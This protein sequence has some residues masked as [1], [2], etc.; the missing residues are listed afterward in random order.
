M[1]LPALQVKVTLEE[2]KVDP[3]GGLSI[4]AAPVGVG[5]GVDGGVAVGV[6]VGVGVEVCVGWKARAMHWTFEGIEAKVLRTLAG[7]NL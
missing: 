2:V 7:V 6:G 1:A 5:V 3:G 4:T